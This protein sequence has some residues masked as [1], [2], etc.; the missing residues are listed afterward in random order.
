[1]T[2][3][4][5]ANL[6]NYPIVTDS[7]RVRSAASGGGTL[8]EKD[9]DYTIT[10]GTKSTA[11][12]IRRTVGSTIGSGAT[13]YVSYVYA[14]WVFEQGKDILSLS[15]EIDDSELYR[16]VEVTGKTEWGGTC[17]GSAS[18]GA[19]DYSTLPAQK[20][21]IIKDESATT[22]EECD[23]IAARKVVDFTAKARR[24]TFKAI[25]NPYVEVGDC[26]MI[27]EASSTI[28]EIYRI[29]SLGHDVKPQGKPVYTIDITAYYYGYAPA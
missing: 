1:L 16:T 12:N 10:E 14:A 2:G 22:S 6:T 24:A 11:W 29:A 7:I 28:S 13:V 9:T 23:V 19:A 27:A 4:T 21:L 18:Y 17:N 5:P 20:V 15:Y 25:G 3:T 8:Y 26:I